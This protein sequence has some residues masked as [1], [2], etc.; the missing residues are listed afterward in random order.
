MKVSA[1][2]SNRKSILQGQNLSRRKSVKLYELQLSCAYLYSWVCLL[3]AAKMA[4]LSNSVIIQEDSWRKMCL[5]LE[6]EF[7]ILYSPGGRLG[8]SGWDQTPSTSPGNTEQ[9]C[10]KSC[11]SLG[12][13][14]PSPGIC[15]HLCTTDLC[16]LSSI[17]LLLIFI[18]RM[19]RTQ[20]FQ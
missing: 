17:R 15:T 18:G 4:K 9:G 10:V 1:K 7:S 11:P 20:S 12:H 19:S 8:M 6:T 13:Q 16:P 3:G 2:I 5:S 14:Q